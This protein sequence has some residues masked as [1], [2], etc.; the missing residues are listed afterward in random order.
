MLWKVFYFKTTTTKKKK[1]KITEDWNYDKK[2]S[3]IC[4]A[5]VDKDQIQQE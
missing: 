2:K 5:G 1:N 4:L 3:S